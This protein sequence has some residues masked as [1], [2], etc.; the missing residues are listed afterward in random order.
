MGPDGDAD[1]GCTALPLS[2]HLFAAGR[3]LSQ[4]E[5]FQQA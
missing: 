2:V 3:P 4:I 5:H 1:M